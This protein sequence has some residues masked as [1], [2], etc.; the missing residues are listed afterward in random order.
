MLDKILHDESLKIL[1]TYSLAVGNF[2]N[3]DSNKGDALGFKLDSIEKT[4]DTKSFDNKQTALMYIVKK[5]ELDTKKELVD[6]SG[7]IFQVNNYI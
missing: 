1:L 7:K 3:G 6:V 4:A 2:L 5:A